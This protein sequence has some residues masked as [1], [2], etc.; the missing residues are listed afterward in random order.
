MKASDY[1][2]KH[3]KVLDGIRALAIMIIVWYHI[4][5][6]SWLIPNIGTISLDFIPRYGFLLVDMMILI[7]AFCLFIP[8][9]RAMVYKEKMPKTKDFYIKRMAKIFPSYFASMII[10]I[11]FLIITNK[12]QFNTFFFKDT[13]MHIFFVH[14]WSTDTILY[15]NY[16]GALWTVA[17]EVQFY[18]LFPIIAK[19]FTKKPTLTYAI[20][21]IVGVICSCI[22][23][24]TATNETL[25]YYVNHFLTFIPVFANGI[26]ASWFYITYTKNKKRTNISDISFTLISIILLL[27][28]RY[29]IKSIGFNNVQ[30]WQLVNRYFLSWIFTGFVVSTCLSIKLYR[31][32]FDNKIM[33]F[34]ALISFNLYIY[35]S[36]IAIKLKEFRIP[37]YSGDTP[38]NMTGNRTWQWQYTILCFVIAIIVAIIMTYLIEK[39]FDKYIRKK[40]KIKEKK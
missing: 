28:Y 21:M 30:E 40:F 11:I 29:L 33:K 16:I 1:D 37:F 9:A 19:C 27:S 18:L 2:T 35:H 5:Q 7:S 15:T 34:I 36:F 31:K 6:Q 38:P 3:I 26:L 25:P 22:I 20:T 14:N 4:W 23:Q 24:T 10:I 8:Y 32:I 17:I 12:I 13:I 39:P